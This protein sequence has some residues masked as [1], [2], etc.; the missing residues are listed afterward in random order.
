MVSKKAEC[1]TGGD[2][3]TRDKLTKRGLVL[4]EEIIDDRPPHSD[5]LFV[6]LEETWFEKQFEHFLMPRFSRVL[7]TAEGR[8]Q[9]TAGSETWHVGETEIDWVSG[10]R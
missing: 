9:R 4:S 8:N 3:S 7:V 2:G 10:E 6:H 5:A 1:S